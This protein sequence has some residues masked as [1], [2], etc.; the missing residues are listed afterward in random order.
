[1]HG[2]WFLLASALCLLSATAQST[3]QDAVNGARGNYS[4]AVSE[5]ASVRTDCQ[6]IPGSGNCDFA[7]VST[8]RLSLCGT[9]GIQ[10]ECS[11]EYQ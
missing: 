3:P 1:M 7:F 10:G 8:A 6:K 2:L 11:Q 4:E 9:D 5:F